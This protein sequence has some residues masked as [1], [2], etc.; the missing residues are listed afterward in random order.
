MMTPEHRGYATRI[1]IFYA[2]FFFP[3]GIYLP[4]FGVWLED[5]GMS[6]E[7]IGFLLTIPMITRVFCTPIMAGFSDRLGDRKL[8]LILYCGFYTMTFGLILLDDSLV[9]VASI[10]TISYIAHSA[11]VPVSDSLALA[12]TRR[13][14]LDYGKMRSWGSIAFMASNL[15][16]G[17]FLD[18]LGA[19]SII[20]ILVIGN[21]LHTTASFILPVDPRRIDNKRLG[22]APR[23]EWSQLREFVQPGFWLILLS[24][25]AIQASHSL[26]YAFGTIYWRDIGISANM[27]GIFWS[28]SVASEVILLYF[29]KRILGFISWRTMLMIG[30]IMATVRWTIMPMHL[31]EYGYLI[32]QL[33]HAGTFASSHLGVM[34]FISETVDDSVS[35]TAQ[36]L[37]TMMNGLITAVATLLSG[38]FF[39]QWQGD[40]FYFM[41]AT[42]LLSFFVLLMSRLFP[43]GKI[44][45][46]HK[47]P[48]TA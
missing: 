23:L 29:S 25:S 22:K 12:G 16:G 15:V 11:I 43:V 42:G 6:A 5:L 26:L 47:D 1:S 2:A 36:G 34:F 4:Y 17:V 14:G 8:A 32:L 37:Y 33:F 38:V 10:M 35:G 45:A 31:P 44:G 7:E 20:W 41:A 3:F 24:A 48:G 21:L 30:A 9:W 13:Y 46:T 27:T 39:A 28:V 18:A 40:A 19:S